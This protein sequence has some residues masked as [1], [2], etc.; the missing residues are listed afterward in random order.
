MQRQQHKKIGEVWICVDLRKLNDPYIHDPFTTPFT[1]EVLEGVGGLEMYSFIDGF[2]G[3][4]Q[5]RIA[6]EDRHKTTFVTEW[7][8][9]QYTAMPF[10]LKNA[11]VIFSQVVV[12]AFKYFIQ[13]FLQVY[14]DDCIAYGLIRDHLENLRLILEIC[15]Q[16]YIALSSK[17]S[18]FCSHFGCY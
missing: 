18:I 12:T 6:K 3:Y 5:I 4:H 2:Y 8:C 11:P 15:R 16:W 9:F 7:G 13:K 17:K 1:D 14:M 10:G